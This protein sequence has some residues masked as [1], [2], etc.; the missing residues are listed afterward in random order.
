MLPPALRNSVVFAFAFAALLTTARAERPLQTEDAGVLDR[1]QC[2]V[3]SAFARLSG[4][5]GHIRNGYAQLGCGVFDGTQWQLAAG[6]TRGG[7]LRSDDLLFTGK[8]SVIALTDD[9]PGL[10]IA[11]GVQGARS[12]GEGWRTTQTSVKAVYS[13]PVGLW[14]LHG[15]LG[16]SRD[17]RA[18]RDSAL[19]NLAAERTELGPFDLMGEVY[20]DDRSPAWVGVGARWWVL[21]K[22]VWLDASYGLQLSAARPRLATV[23]VSLL[24]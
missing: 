8:T 15:N 7:G 24:F 4:D 5:D 1:G 2:Q 16:W 19:W 6:R 10:V 14:L 12:S 13:A 21:P 23:G 3:Q 20:G 9:R 17:I 22:R 11:Y 18:H